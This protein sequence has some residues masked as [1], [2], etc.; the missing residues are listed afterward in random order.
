MVPY[1]GS[2]G[3]E[4]L[5]LDP[6]HVR[7]RLAERRAVRNHLGSVHAVALANLGELTTGLAVLGALPPGVRGILVGLDIEYTKKARGVLEAEARADVPAVHEPTDYTAVAEIRDGAGDVVAV[8]RARWRL[9][10]V[11]GAERVAPGRPSA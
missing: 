10:T 5:R 3:A 8:L 4:V 11:P 7:V 9:S 6:G 1:S 2:L